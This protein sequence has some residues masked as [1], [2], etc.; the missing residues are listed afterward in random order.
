[1]GDRRPRD[2]PVLVSD[3]NK[4]RLSLG[5]APKFPELEEQIVHEGMWCRDDM[6]NMCVRAPQPVQIAN[7]R[8]SLGLSTK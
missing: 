8:L 7:F 2:A 1:M 5:W 6:P 4:A 3:S